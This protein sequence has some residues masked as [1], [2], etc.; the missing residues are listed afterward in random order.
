MISPLQN[1]LV[2]KRPIPLPPAEKGRTFG[3]GVERELERIFHLEM[4]FSKS[5][6]ERIKK[7]RM[8]RYGNHSVFSE[9]NKSCV[10]FLE[11]NCL[12]F[13]HNSTA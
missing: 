6:L 2:A 4:H 3:G 13:S 7:S 9:R 1:F 11:L 12:L 8:D 10:I 5:L